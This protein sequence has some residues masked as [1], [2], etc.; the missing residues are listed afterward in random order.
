VEAVLAAW[1]GEDR[2]IYGNPERRKAERAVRAA[3]EAS[4]DTMAR[5]KYEMEAED[6]EG[7]SG[8][9]LIPPEVV[10]A[11]CLAM[12]GM[13]GWEKLAE[14]ERED[15]RTDVEAAIRAALDKLGLREPEVRKAS[16][17]LDSS[18]AEG[19]R[20]RQRAARE[21]GTRLIDG[22]GER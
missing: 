4:I 13:S 12:P 2:G 6:D 19:L 15:W 1:Y 21:K 5:R 9:L 8:G 18:R 17:P 10:E 14:R 20:Q 22:E 3:R 11:A 7:S 16:N